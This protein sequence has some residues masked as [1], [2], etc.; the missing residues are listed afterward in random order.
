MYWGF[1]EGYQLDMLQIC[2][3]GKLYLFF[4]FQGFQQKESKL[5]NSI[6]LKIVKGVNI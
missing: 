5:R 1:L 6:I 4:E 2:S 3:F